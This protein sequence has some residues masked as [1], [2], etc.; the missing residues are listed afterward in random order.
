MPLLQF[1]PQP[2]GAD[3]AGGVGMDGGDLSYPEFAAESSTSSIL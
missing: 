1:L 3:G 2:C